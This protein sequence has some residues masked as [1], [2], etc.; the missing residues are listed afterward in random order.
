MQDRQVVA[1]RF[2]GGRASNNDDILAALRRFN[3]L[4][5][6]NVEFADISSTQRRAEFGIK[7]RGDG[8]VTRRTGGQA[9]PR[10]DVLYEVRVE[11]ET[12]ESIQWRNDK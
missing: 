9:F 10:S 11:A 7:K 3:R 8:C 5:L 4:R 2:A 6:M 12:G 1:Q